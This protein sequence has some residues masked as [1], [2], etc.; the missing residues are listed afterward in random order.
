MRIVD[1]VSKFIMLT[2]AMLLVGGQ[3]TVQ[4]FVVEGIQ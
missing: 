4:Q 1:F 2:M 3:Q